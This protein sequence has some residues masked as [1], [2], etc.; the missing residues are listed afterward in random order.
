VL[1]PTLLG[2]PEHGLVEHRAVAKGGDGG[3]GG[4]GVEAD[5]GQ[6]AGTKK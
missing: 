6:R 3:V 4:R 2:K 1:R 5:E